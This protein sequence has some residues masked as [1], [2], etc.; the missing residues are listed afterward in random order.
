MGGHPAATIREANRALGRAEVTLRLGM[1]AVEAGAG[2]VRLANGA[3]LPAD[4]LIWAA[5]TIA[6]TLY[7]YSGLSVDGQGELLVQDTLQAV[8]APG[9]FA[10]G[11]SVRIRTYA[12]PPRM[13]VD[14]ARVV[15]ILGHNLEMAM[16][17]G[18]EPAG[19]T[20][21]RSD[22]PGNA[23]RVFRPRARF[24]VLRDTGDGQAILSYGQVAF[25][26]P[27]VMWLKDRS[28]RKFVARFQALASP[29]APKGSAG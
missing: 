3:V 11:E 26:A 7:R 27:W 29:S 22:S 5:G 2:H 23:Y 25:T 28:D 13:D 10:A 19:P 17:G 8:G 21:S 18:A 6:P 4:V 24:P 14:A 12:G 1:T 16:R 20:R 15:P 9:I